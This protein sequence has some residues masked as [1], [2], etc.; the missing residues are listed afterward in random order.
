MDRRQFVALL[1][2]LT[3][4]G[5]STDTGTPTET[6]RTTATATPTPSRTASRSPSSRPPE[7]PAETRTQTDTATP[8]FSPV[9]YYDSC[10]Q[11]SVQAARY[12]RV[13]LFF[14]DSAQQF[15]AGYRGTTP[16]RG[17]G[18]DAGTVV[19]EVAVERGQQTV[20]RVN[21]T[22]ESCLATPTP[23]PTE[24]A[25]PTQR[26]DARRGLD[27]FSYERVD[28][29]P[30][31]VFVRIENENSYAVETFTTTEFFGDDGNRYDIQYDYRRAGAGARVELVH[32]YAGPEDPPITDHVV[33]VDAER[34]D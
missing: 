2:T 19:S 1:G 22:L 28:T 27:V 15:D 5:C 25:T 10:E 4:A 3:A 16:F 31:E 32:R 13:T 18:E 34:A 8:V 21:P 12:D 17:T 23:A 33:T 14:E 30:Y 26:S 11:V 20:T 29:E 9:I 7:S 6:G 24:T